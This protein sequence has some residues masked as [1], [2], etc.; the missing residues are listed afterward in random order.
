MPH[1][2]DA[3]V[4]PRADTRRRLLT[5]ALLVAAVLAPLRLHFR[6]A[7]VQGESMLP[8]LAPGDLLVIHTRAYLRSAP[9]R[10]DLV[11]ARWGDDLVVKRIVGLPGETVELRNGLL[12]I[13]DRPFPE[14]HPILSGNLR[15][16]KGRLRANHYALL[17]D[18]RTV[19]DLLPVHA[20]VPRQAI[21]G[22][23]VV[24]F[25]LRPHDTLISASR[26]PTQPPS[27]Q[28]SA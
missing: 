4:R 11:I 23:V 28:T 6:L 18:N 16:S 12:Q 17:G 7:V 8:T 26:S 13:N 15:L 19:T 10:G 9:Q 24:I 14:T 3:T 20:V 5:A 2:S 25:R 21:L 1:P 22:K 27:Q